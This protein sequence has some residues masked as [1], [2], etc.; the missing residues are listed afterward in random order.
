MSCAAA[1]PAGTSYLAC[2]GA[3]TCTEDGECECDVGK[4]GRTCR[5]QRSTPDNTQSTH[6]VVASR[7]S[8]SELTLLETL[9][10]HCFLRATG[11]CELSCPNFEG[12][13]CAG[14]GDCDEHGVC[15]CY[16]GYRGT[17]CS[18]KCPGTT[19]PGQPH[20]VICSGHGV[21]GAN[22]CECVEGWYGTGCREGCPG[23][24]DNICSGHGT[25]GGSLG[26][27]QCDAAYVTPTGTGATTLVHGGGIS[28]GSVWLED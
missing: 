11:A 19:N 22:G 6:G 1:C 14:H 20:A 24:P 13:N 4:A 28:Y 8:G 17:D 7:I 26:K 21:C 12:Q 16:P 15:V 10:A 18:S 2:S 27:C 23:A 9:T 25:C 5:K 3:G